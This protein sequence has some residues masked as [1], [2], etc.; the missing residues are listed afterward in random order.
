MR[1]A[2]AADAPSLRGALRASVLTGL[3]GQA[4]LIVSGVVVA[5]MLGVQNRGSLAL[6]TVLPLMITLFGALGLPLALTYEIARAPSIAVPLLQ[7]LARFIAIQTLLLTLLHLAVLALVVHARADE[8]QLAALLTTVAVPALI[9]L[10]YGLAVLQGQQRY[11][12]FNALRLAPAALYAALAFALFAVGSGTL[13]MFAAGVAASW[14]AVGVAT[15]VL[16]IKGGEPAQSTAVLPPTR[17]LLRFGMRGMLGSASPSDG[18]GVDQ[19]VVGIFLSTRSLG[20]YVVAAAFM[21]LS[22]LVTQSIGLVAYPNVAARRDA[23]D[24]AR[25]MWRFTALG[26]AAALAVTVALAFSVGRLIEILFGQSFAAADGVARVLLVAALFA[27]TRRVL[28]DAARG[29]NRPLAGTVAEITSW[30][31]LVGAMIVLTPLM[32]HNGV[33]L[34][35]VIASAVSLVVLVRGLRRAVGDPVEHVVPRRAQDALVP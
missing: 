4:A 28:S 22:R 16:A 31:V 30:A 35:L 27:G 14:L 20:L 3:A 1:P 19:A 21:N 32:E 2:S 6:L 24:A 7:R 13:P 25:A 5:R 23:D 18:A 11:R 10:Q 34:A 17:R 8:V 33:A 26:A 29:A 9:A 12:E 15:V